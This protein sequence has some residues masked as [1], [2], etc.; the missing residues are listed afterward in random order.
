MHPIHLFEAF[1][2]E[3]EYMVV[4]R[5]TL[6]VRPI[7]DQLLE[8]A[9]RLPGAVVPD[10]EAAAHPGSVEVGDIAWSNEL[11]AHVLEFKTNGPARSLDGLAARFH[12]AAAQANALLARHDACL[13]PGGMH[14][15]MNPD[16]E[17]KLWPHG[18]SDVYAAFNRIFDCK[19]HGWANL[20]SAHLNL[21]FCGDAEF[22]ALHAAIRV[23]LPIMPALSAASPVMDGVPTGLLDNRLEVYR[24]NARRVPITSGKVIPEPVYTK[25]DYERVIFEAIYE[26]FA[27]LD[28]QGVLRHEW[29]NSRGAIARFMRDAIEVRVLDCQECP[30]ADLAIVALVTAAVRAI[31]TG[32]LAPLDEVKAWGVEPLHAILLST[33]RDA[34]R[35]RIDDRAYLAM[36]GVDA[37]SATAGEIW[38]SL[39]TR[40]LAGPGRAELE[41]H[42]PALSVILEQGPLARRIAAR[43]GGGIEPLWRALAACLANNRLLGE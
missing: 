12:A 13:L 28:P 33:I 23:L 14:P 24:H 21:P 22:G 27:P 10:D 19:G 32:G 30:R 8:E 36:L 15:T 5:R 2:V 18:Y 34:E 9:S 1:G 40:L 20:Q 17:M 4:D 11:A 7:V 35:A 31:A 37:P 29:C 6:A 41:E 25:A 3:I 43:L 16:V 26:A 42:M 38:K 39:L